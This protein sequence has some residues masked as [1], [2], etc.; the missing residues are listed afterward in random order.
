MR[1]CYAEQSLKTKPNLL[2]LIAIRNQALY[3]KLVLNIRKLQQ[4][5]YRKKLLRVLTVHSIDRG[6]Q[7]WCINGMLHNENGPAY[8]TSSGEKQW[9]INGKHHRIDGPAL[10]HLNG[11]Q[12]W[13]VN[14]NL[15]RTDGPAIIY[16]SK[17]REW[18][19]CGKRHRIDGPAVI[20]FSGEEKWYLHGV[21]VD[22]F[23]VDG[24]NKN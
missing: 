11:Y 17:A 23:P 20:K 8:I 14:G 21:K 13:Y 10:I 15:H 5:I 6:D 2:F 9:W 7:R 22:P 12:R 24:G 16:T 1:R 19:V 4:P 3:K 18:W